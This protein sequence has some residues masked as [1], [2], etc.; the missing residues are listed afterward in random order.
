MSKISNVAD[1]VNI[2]QPASTLDDVVS[3]LTN[4]SS[5]IRHL[6]VH[7]TK[8]GAKSPMGSTTKYLKEHKYFTQKG[9]EIRFQQVRNTWIQGFA[10]NPKVPADIK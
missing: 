2:T 9:T 6:M 7:F 5:R 10:K 8:E 4:T 3:K 1:Q